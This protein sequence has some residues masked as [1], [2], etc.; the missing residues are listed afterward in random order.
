MVGLKS[1][2]SIP[3]HR[4]WTFPS[5]G[6]E[7]DKA[8]A[9]IATAT[10]ATHLVTVRSFEKWLHIR[11]GLERDGFTLDA[12]RIGEGPEGYIIDRISA[13]PVDGSQPNP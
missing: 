3:A 10:Q 2:E 13:R 8:I 4:R 9:A 11:E 5:C 12:L 7:R 1:P 6:A